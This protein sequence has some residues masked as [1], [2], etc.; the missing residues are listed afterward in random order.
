MALEESYV[1]ERL[2]HLSIIAGVYQEIGI[3]AWLGGQEPGKAPRL[4]LLDELHYQLWLVLV[5]V[6]GA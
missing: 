4:Q 5:D 1:N 3:A 6:A 2:D